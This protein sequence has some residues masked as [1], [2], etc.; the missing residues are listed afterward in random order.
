MPKPKTRNLLM[1][2][3]IAASLL[4]GAWPGRTQEQG[5]A[6]VKNF[7]LVSV[8]V[9]ETKIWL[10]SSIIVEQGDHVKLTL[11]NMI[12]GA[13]NQHGFALPGYG[14]TEVITAGTPKT[15]EFVASKP[16][17]FTYYCQLHPAHIGGQLLVLHKM[18]SH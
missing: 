6:N 10:P 11:K 3:A 2:A 17:V 15:V 16:G 4:L 5:E 18:R 1:V 9:D 7:T 14:I 8:M 13:G 12:P